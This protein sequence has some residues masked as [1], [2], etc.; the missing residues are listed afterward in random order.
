MDFSLKVSISK[1]L[2]TSI[3]VT[4]LFSGFIT[5]FLSFNEINLSTVLIDFLYLLLSVHLFCYLLY[6]YFSNKKIDKTYF[7]IALFWIFL[8]ICTLLKLLIFDP[9]PLVERILGLRNNIF[10]GILILYI[11]LLVKRTE[12]L[13]LLVNLLFTTGAI[14]IVFSIIQYL[15]SSKFPN[16]LMVLRGEESFGFYGT[17]IVRPTALLGNTIIFASFTLFLFSYFLSKCLFNYEKKYLF[18]LVI[19]TLA[20]ILTFTRATLVGMLIVLTVGFFLRYG[21]LTVSFIRKLTVF[22]FTLIASILLLAFIYQDSFIMRRLTGKE[23]STQG[24]TNVHLNEILDSIDY[25]KSH[26]MAGSGI[27][28]QGASGAPE[29]KI[30]TDGYWFQLFLEN[31][32]LLGSL[33][34]IFYS[35]CLIYSIRV[36]YRTQSM[37]HKQICMTFILISMY[38]FCAS[39][40]NSAFAGRTNFIIYWLLLGVLVSQNLIEKKSSYDFDSN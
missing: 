27:G 9:N 28:S 38:F 31:G 30:I 22:A 18:A 7:E 29:N 15:F 14:L 3:I 5:N 10:Y 35:V 25:L 6:C 37:W 11:P 12:H 21:R 13:K 32:L 1:V 33:Y 17:S 20:N 39:F 4:L 16:S 24:S 19:V 26:Y 40:L 23:A 8:F 2:L 34:V 36:Y